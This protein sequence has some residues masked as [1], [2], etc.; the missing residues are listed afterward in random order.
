MLPMSGDDSANFAQ[1]ETFPVKGRVWAVLLL[2]FCC[3]HAAFLIASIVPRQTASGKKGS[4]AL[5]LYRIFVSGDQQWNMFETIPLLHSFDVRIEV[6]SGQGGRATV[7]SVLPGFAP[8]PQPEFSR[9]YVMFHRMLLN[10]TSPSFFEAYLRKTDELLR[11]R[12]GGSSTGRW[13]LVVDMEWTRT[14][15]HS[16]GDGVLYVPATRSFDAANPRGVSP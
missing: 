14:L 12:H 4:P 8:Y 7:G 2:G 9:Y 13:A 16:R 5:N 15:I 6:D 10:S 1:G 3:W 11:A